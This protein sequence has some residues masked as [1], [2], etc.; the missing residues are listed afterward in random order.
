MKIG[1]RLFEAKLTEKDFQTKAI[2]IVENYEGFNQVFDKDLL[3]K[4]DKRYMNYQLIRN[5]LAAYKEKC[6]FTL[7]VDES[8]ID[9]IRSL[10][11]TQMTV[12]NGETRKE[13]DFITWQEIA[14]ACGKDLKDY[15]NKKYFNT[16][17]VV[18]F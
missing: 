8:R 1:N 11:V 10:Q 14:S 12:K 13:I 16:N 18:K 3:L 9:L 4:T 5:I 2:Q 17:R 7:L 15:L 6:S